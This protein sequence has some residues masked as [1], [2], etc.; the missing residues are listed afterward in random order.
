MYTNR[1][2]SQRNHLKSLKPGRLNFQPSYLQEQL[3]H[4]FITKSHF[5]FTISHLRYGKSEILETYLEACQATKME[6]SAPN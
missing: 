6:L 3:C 4:I 1:I 2:L 5:S